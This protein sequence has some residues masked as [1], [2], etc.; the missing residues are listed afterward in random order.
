MKKILL[1]ADDF[2]GAN[3][4]G[5][6]IVQRGY[7]VSINLDGEYNRENQI[8]IIDSE[9]RNLSENKAYE[10]VD[11][12]LAKIN[13]IS[14]YLFVYKKIDS[15]LRGNI[16]QEYNAI[17]KHLKP[18]Y[19]IFAPAHPNLKRTTKEGIQCVNYKRI[20]ETEF[21]QDPKKPVTNDDIRTILSSDYLHHDLNE[22]RN[23][24]NLQ[25]GVNTFDCETYDDLL[26]ISDECL[27]L[28]D[29][30][31]FIGSAGLLD[32]LFDKLIIKKPALGIVGSVSSQNSYAIKYC[33]KMGIPIVEIDLIDYVENNYKEKIYLI[34][35]YLE[36][37]KD[38]IIVTS[39][40][41]DNYLE[42]VKYLEDRK[43]NSDLIL[44]K[45]IREITED[46]IKNS[47][48]SGI[49][50]TGGTTS[51]ELLKAIKA[52]STNLIEEIEDG[53]ILSKI[54]GIERELYLV[55]K[56]GSFGNEKTIYNAIN[57]IRRISI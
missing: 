29:R 22:V 25:P 8:T 53:V 57:E 12:I 10:I 27:K 56:A 2:T 5:I 44:S 30:V 50:V 34:S 21:A 39:K 43:L 33:E 46:V 51:I 48:I 9:S 20:L 14:D 49:F 47:E 16:R 6:K 32:S 40:D 36:N 54:I 31:L 55:T 37:N 13:D 18:K 19:V 35:K 1:L 38:V 23:K 45:L 28:K 7:R 15:T 52:K 4:S 17:V 42:S 11:D 41:R 3:D 26:K 24:I